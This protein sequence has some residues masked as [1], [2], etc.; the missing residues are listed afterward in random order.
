MDDG[1]GVGPEFGF[2]GM[3]GSCFSVEGA[4]G[5]ESFDNVFRVEAFCVCDAL[6]LID[7]GEDHLVCKAEA[8]D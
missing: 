4:H 8:G 6:L 3:G 7:A 1:V 5:I 2:G